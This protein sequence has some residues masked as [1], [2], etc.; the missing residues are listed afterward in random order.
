[1]VRAH[2]KKG[3]ETRRLYNGIGMCKRLATP[4]AA[5]EVHGE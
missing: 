3:C 1:M 4:K 2:R 5:K